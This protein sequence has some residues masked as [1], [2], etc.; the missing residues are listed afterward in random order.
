MPRSSIPQTV[1]PLCRADTFAL[2]GALGR[3][4]TC[5][6]EVE[7]DG[8]ATQARFT[9]LPAK[10]EHLSAE[11]QGRWLTR[12]AMFANVDALLAD[13]GVDDEEVVYDS[14]ADDDYDEAGDVFVRAGA[15]PY[16]LPISFATGLLVLGCL[17]MAALSMGAA[18]WVLRP[19]P[20]AEPAALIA[21]AV[22]ETLVAQT[23]S[24]T[25]TTGAVLPGGELTA[26]VVV[27]GAQPE[28]PVPPTPELSLDPAQ[29]L[30]PTT[31]LPA[32]PAQLESPLSPTPPQ[33]PLAPPTLTPALPT[34]PL[35]PPTL[36]AP[37]TPDPGARPTPALPLPP[38]FTPPPVLPTLPLTPTLPSGPTVTP[39]PPTQPTIGPTPTRTNTPIPPTPTLSPG[40]QT[41][42]GSLRITTINYSGAGDSVE[43]VEIVNESPQQ[44][45]ASGIELRWDIPVRGNPLNQEPEA[46]DFP[47]GY[48]ILGNATCRIYTL[49]QPPY[50]PCV[51]SW[52]YGPANLWPDEVNRGNTARLIDTINNR[53]LARFTY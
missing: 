43:Y 30:P 37:P 19:T 7:L 14:A 45:N 53:E 48:V 42:F 28:F 35:A 12:R 1:C 13:D 50:A 17:C 18:Y 41:F 27:I 39:T 33:P 34:P 40:S 20:E 22:R 44:I 26:T 9:H 24:G 6:C 29:P 15:S 47:V 11:L 8:K 49:K 52:G 36:P 46:F 21:Q 10:Y 25:L 32:T 5:G 23:L 16:V 31:E 3:C 51:H 38:T 2:K 4:R